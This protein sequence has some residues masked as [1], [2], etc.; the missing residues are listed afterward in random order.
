MSRGFDPNDRAARMR[1]SSIA[2]APP[3][4]V[5]T[6]VKKAPRKMT[7]MILSSVVGQKMI[8][9]GTQA[10]GGIGRR[11]SRGGNQKYRNV[12]LIAIKS[13]TG[14]PMSCASANPD[15]TREK[16]A[17]QS[18]QNLLFPT[19]LSSEAKTSVGAGTAERNGKCNRRPISQNTRSPRTETRPRRRLKVVLFFANAAVATIQ[20]S[21]RSPA[22][23]ALTASSRTASKI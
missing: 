5:R 16:L 19:I 23:K 1:R 7:K 15:S 14:I 2:L 13:P 4:T 21:S 22:S 8:D 18:F 11:I 3:S 12:R 6:T 20:A 9:V 17:I 10:S